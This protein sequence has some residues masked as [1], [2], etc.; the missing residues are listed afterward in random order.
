MRPL[1]RAGLLH[2]KLLFV[3]VFQLLLSFKNTVRHYMLQPTLTSFL[4]I[5]VWCQVTRVKEIW[6]SMGF[7]RLIKVKFKNKIDDE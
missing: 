6:I 7:I 4:R 2:L 5:A 1:N 3:V